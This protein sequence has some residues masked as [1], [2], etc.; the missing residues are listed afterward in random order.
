MSGPTAPSPPHRSSR[1]PLL[2]FSA[3]TALY[4]AWVLSLP[5]FPSQDGPMHLFFTQVFLGLLTHSSPL[6]A[7]YYYIRH[8][9]PPYS[10]YYYLLIAISR[11]VPLLWADKIVVALAIANLAFGTRALCIATGRSG[12]WISL[13]I[14]PLLLNWPLFMG[15]VNFV[16][17]LGLGAW[18]FA[19]WLHPA[20]GHAPHPARRRIGLVLLLALMVLTHPVPA[21]LVLIV[22]ALDVLLRA[23]AGL[24]SLRAARLRPNPWLN[25]ALLLAFAGIAA[26]AYVSAFT[27]RHITRQTDPHVPLATTLGRLGTLHGLILFGGAQ[28]AVLLYRLTAYVALLLP[29]VLGFRAGSRNGRLWLCLA[30]VLLVALPFI[31]PDLNGSH[32][33]R[34]RLPI[35]VCLAAFA[36]AS[37]GPALS[38]RLQKALALYAVFAALLAVGLANSKLRPVARR[39]AAVDRM[40]PPAFGPVALM[41]TADKNNF[42]DLLLFGPYEWAEVHYIR[43]NHGVLLNTPWLDLPILPIGPRPTLLTG[44]LPELDLDV[45][46]LMREALLHSPAVRRLVYPQTDYVILEDQ[47]GRTP[48][49]PPDPVLAADKRA[50]WSC[51][52]QDWLVICGRIPNA[53]ASITN[54]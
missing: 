50:T 10:L 52:P 23:P 29:L 27:V 8:L 26:A 33:F 45:T 7:H 15:F 54:P 38:P 6:Y 43:R 25:D 41:L 22:C 24:R 18:A 36:A 14:F 30:I 42:K 53:P 4:C 17:S 47:T 51:R 44:Q 32:L 49:Y 31:P 28:P 13:L 34:D 39:I 3:L 21:G 5:L 40:P 16:L 2:I 9:L 12:A 11:L 48:A 1:I 35:V 20:P 19:L 46:F 37:S